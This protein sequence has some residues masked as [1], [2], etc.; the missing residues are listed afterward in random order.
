VSV[1]QSGFSRDQA[2]QRVWVQTQTLRRLIAF[3][4]HREA[5]DEPFG[6]DS[7]NGCVQNWCLGNVN[8]FILNT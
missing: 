5:K 3:V 6:S 1:H 8:L 2:A 7:L 4:D